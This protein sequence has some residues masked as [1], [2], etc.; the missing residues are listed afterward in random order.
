MSKWLEGFAYKSEPVF[1]KF[2]IP[3]LA[4]FLINMLIIIVGADRPIL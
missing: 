2:I 1:M 4:S 3:G